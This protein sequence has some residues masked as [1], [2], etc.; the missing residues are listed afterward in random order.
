MDQKLVDG[1]IQSVFEDFQGGHLWRKNLPIFNVSP[2]IANMYPF[3]L[4]SLN[5]ILSIM[6]VQELE[7]QNFDSIY[8]A[9]DWIFKNE[10]SQ[11]RY[12]NFT[13]NEMHSTY[14]KK[15]YS[16]WASP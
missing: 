4:A 13:E 7:K 16:G 6:E 14:S 12:V 15:T 11:Y 10:L 2:Q 1:I 5:E 9:I 8:Q 3:G